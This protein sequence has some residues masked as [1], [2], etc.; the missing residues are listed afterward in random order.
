MDGSKMT[1]LNRACR[2]NE[3]VLRTLFLRH[4]KVLFDANVAAITEEHDEAEQPAAAE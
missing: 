3:K 1:E 4:P 2:L